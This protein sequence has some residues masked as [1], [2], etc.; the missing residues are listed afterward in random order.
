MDFLHPDTTAALMLFLYTFIIWILILN[1]LLA[2]VTE[3]FLSRAET[4]RGS[5]RL[6]LQLVARGAL[7]GLAKVSRRARGMLQRRSARLAH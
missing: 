1:M 3:S 6:T 5:D 7:T 4:R 2:I